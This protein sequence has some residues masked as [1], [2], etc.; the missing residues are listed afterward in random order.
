MKMRIRIAVVQ[1]TAALWLL[2]SLLGCKPKTELPSSEVIEQTYKVEPNASLRIA[3]P[4]GSISIRGADT[5]EVRIRAVKSASSAG[6]LKEI[7]LDVTAEPGDVLIKTGFPRKKNMP[8]F[9]GAAAV[10]Y[11]L[12]V[13]HST[14]IAR[15]D[16]DDG[17][18]S[19][20]GIQNSDV[21]AN[22]V[23]GQ[24]NIRNCCGD[25]KVAVANGALDMIY[26]RCEG[27]YFSADVQVLN[28]NVRLSVA[29]GAALR[30]RG[31][32]VNGKIMNNTGAMVGLQGQL[33]RKIDLPFGNGRRCDLTVRVTSGDITIVA[34]EPG[35]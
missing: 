22:V 31:E 15:V 17:N 19:I 29:R 13:P 9:A 25:L 20:E 28:G 8:F 7:T 26:G 2:L 12:S 14:R 4:R 35:G 6:H 16:V 27:P 1:I 34:A 10:D 5:S 23:N 32:T 18:V 30:V 21:W 24:L 33:L 11:T 3:N